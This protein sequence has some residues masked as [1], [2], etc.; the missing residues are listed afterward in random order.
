MNPAQY[1]RRALCCALVLASAAAALADSS[2]VV[3]ATFN[4]TTNV[5]TIS[6]T[7]LASGKKAPEVVFNG[8]LVPAVYDG[9]TGQVRATLATTPAPGTYVVQLANDNDSSMRVDLAIG[10]V[11][12]TGPQGPQG[13]KGDTGATGATGP[14][15]PQGPAGPVGAQGPTGATG[16]QGP[17]GLTGPQGAQGPKGETGATGAVGPQGPQGLQGA[18]GDAGP[19][20]AVGP[21]GLKG[22]KG[23]KGDT[24][25]MGPQGPKGD[26][27]DPGAVGATG[28]VGPQGPKGDTGAIGPQGPQGNPGATGATGPQGLKGD[29]GPTGAAGSPG[30][31]GPSGPT[32]P[33]GPQGPQGPAGTMPAVSGDIQLASGA[34]VATVTGLQTR[35]V[36]GVSPTTGQVLTYDGTAWAPATPAAGGASGSPVKFAGATAAGAVPIGAFNNFIP[37]LSV[38]FTVPQGQTWFIQAS[39]SGSVIGYG[40]ASWAAYPAVVN[41]TTGVATYLNGTV[42][43]RLGSSYLVPTYILSDGDIHALAGHTTYYQDASTPWSFTAITTTPLPAGTYS[44]RVHAQQNYSSNTYF[45]YFHYASLSV[46]AFSAQ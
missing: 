3:S 31:A 9:A 6:G 18:Q 43:G 14:A 17:Q 15:G 10:A 46:L 7:K 5:I 38:T 36:S 1:Y 34:N 22:D 24:G 19:Q 2:N 33:Q 42:G 11:G 4:P 30:P 20:G 27:G 28:A 39:A 29:T 12:A 40:G 23:D 16:P 41:S 13:P 35:A 45:T 32:G 21:Q 37:N 8:S 44:V 25:A 26:K